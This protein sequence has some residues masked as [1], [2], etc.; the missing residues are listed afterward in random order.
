M[1]PFHIRLREVRMSCKKTQ[2]STADKL[3]IQLRSY[4]MYEQ[5]KT[6]PSIAKLIAL[7]D[8]FDVSLDRLMVRDDT[9]GGS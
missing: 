2:Q 3:G 1:V 9:G 6:E 7:A 8:F 4:Q 5:G